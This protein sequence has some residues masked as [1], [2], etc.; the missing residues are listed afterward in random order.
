MEELILKY[1]QKIT[2]QLI[3]NPQRLEN[4]L[5]IKIFYLISWI[6]LVTPANDP[7]TFIAS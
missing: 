6:I 1:Q 7:M 2:T 4:H 5:G 3:K